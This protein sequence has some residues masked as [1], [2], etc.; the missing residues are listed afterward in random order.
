MDGTLLK[1]RVFDKGHF[2]VIRK[3]DLQ[4]IGKGGWETLAHVDNAEYRIS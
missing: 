2:S 1:R 4:S 3:V